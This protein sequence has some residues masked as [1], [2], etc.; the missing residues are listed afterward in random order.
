MENILYYLQ[1]AE[2]WKVGVWGLFLKEGWKGLIPALGNKVRTLKDVVERGFNDN[3]YSVR[4]NLLDLLVGHLG[5]FNQQ[6][7]GYWQ[8][9]S[10]LVYGE[11]LAF[12]LFRSRQLGSA[13]FVRAS[14]KLQFH[15]NEKLQV[16]SHG[17]RRYYP[18]R[19]ASFSKENYWFSHTFWGLLGQFCVLIHMRQNTVSTPFIFHYP[20]SEAVSRLNHT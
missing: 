15:M 8:E 16:F 5:N 2:K 13:I 19:K 14:Q 4:K 18:P 3:C 11:R 20:L 17:K 6:V 12:Y 10:S 1:Q 9:F 7:D